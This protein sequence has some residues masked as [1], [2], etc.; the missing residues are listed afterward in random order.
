MLY[1]SLIG[2]EKGTWVC[3]CVLNI[4]AICHH[5]CFCCR[6]DVYDHQSGQNKNVVRTKG[7]QKPKFNCT[8]TMHFSSCSLVSYIFKFSN[9]HQN[10]ISTVLMILRLILQHGGRELEEGHDQGKRVRTLTTMKI[11]IKIPNYIIRI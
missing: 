5:H 2:F 7:S 8:V 11:Y 6:D 1:R 9:M 3:V 4:L 10:H